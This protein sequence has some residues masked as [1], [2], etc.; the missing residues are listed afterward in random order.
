MIQDDDALQAMVSATADEFRA[1]R[2]F[3][4]GAFRA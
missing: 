3:G 4:R 1:R 2:N